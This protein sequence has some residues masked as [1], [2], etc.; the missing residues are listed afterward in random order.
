M[1]FLG[2]SSAEDVSQTSEHK[3]GGRRFECPALMAPELKI[4]KKQQQSFYMALGETFLFRKTFE[5]VELLARPTL[6]EKK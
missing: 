1:P 2:L 3:G 4:L 5:Q 6:L